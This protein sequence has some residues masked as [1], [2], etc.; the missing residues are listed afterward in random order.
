MGRNKNKTMK[1]FSL[2]EDILLEKSDSQFV[3][4]IVP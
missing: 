2:N 1:D 4:P 3:P